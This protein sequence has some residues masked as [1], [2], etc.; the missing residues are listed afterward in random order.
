MFEFAISDIYTQGWALLNF[1]A[2]FF[3]ILG[4][5]AGVLIGAMPGLTAVMGVAVMTPLTY[6]MGITNSFSLLIGVFCGG[7]YGGSITA[8]VANIPGTPSAIMT[9]LDGYPMCKRGE[10]GRAIG[11]ATVASFIGGVI[12]AVILSLFAPLVATM[13]LKFSGQEYFAIG[14]FGLTVI[15]YI[16]KGSMAKG[17]LS[18]F[19]GLL[20]GTIGADPISGYERFTFGSLYLLSGIEIVPVLIGLFGFSE[21]LR[22]LESGFKSVEIA[23]TIGRIIPGK[24]DMK[25]ILPTIL[26]S[27]PIGTIIGA[28]PAAGGTI[29]A[30]V[31]YG[32]EKR[33]SRN[34]EKFGTGAIEGVAAPETANNACIGGAMIPMLTL[35]VP[36]D[37]VTAILIG[38]LMMKGLTPGPTLFSR[39]MEIVSLLFIL[40]MLA[41]CVFLFYGL[42][43]AKYIAKVINVPMRILAPVIVTLCI[44]GTFALRNALFDVWTMLFF[45]CLG[46]L[47]SKVELPTPPLALGL[48]LGK[49]VESE[50]R[51]GLIL[52]RGNV[53]SFFTRPISGTF[54]LLSILMLILPTILGVISKRKGAGRVTE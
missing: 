14:F 6:G 44:V 48:V 32:V 42:L 51:R 13:A 4:T 10:A 9:T 5:L 7:V 17:F 12:S 15:A 3:L 45:G 40:L 35:G 20:V 37:P 34:S 41:N 26:R 38:A 43:G 33:I 21:I 27:A 16:S 53:L 46:Y 29:A 54:L 25:K 8:I 11:I 1:E 50:F 36:G 2:I 47:F 31:A 24:E 49:L 30:I 22:L 19:L 52:S 28:I 23:K 39:N 18:G